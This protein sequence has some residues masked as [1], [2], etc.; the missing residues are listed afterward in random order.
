MLKTIVT[1]GVDPAGKKKKTAGFVGKQF[2][3]FNNFSSKIVALIAKQYLKKKVLLI[4]GWRIQYLP[5]YIYCCSKITVL[6]CY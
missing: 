5:V 2:F 1:R 4:L 3:C 6:Q